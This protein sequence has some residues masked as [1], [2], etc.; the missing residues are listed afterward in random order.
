[1]Q[2]EA[3][4]GERKKKHYKKVYKTGGHNRIKNIKERDNKNES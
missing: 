3:Y 1:M 4:P 2:D